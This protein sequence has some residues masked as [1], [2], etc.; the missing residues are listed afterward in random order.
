MLEAIKQHRSE[1]SNAVQAILKKS[2]A[3]TLGHPAL[4]SVL[5]AGHYPRTGPRGEGRGW[6]LFLTS[7]GLQVR[8]CIVTS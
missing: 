7:K 4:C 5:R 8:S 1:N 6:S 3:K 2:N